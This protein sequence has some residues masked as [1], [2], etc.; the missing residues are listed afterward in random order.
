MERYKNFTAAIYCPVG[1][2]V[3]INDLDEFA[4]RFSWIEEHVRVGKVYLE[5]YRHGLMIDRQQM[6]RIRNFFNNKGIETA[7]GIT[8]D[9]IS[10]GEGG[11]DPLCYTNSD[12]IKLLTE[13]S[14]FTASLFDEIILDDF[15]FTNCRCPSCIRAKGDKTWARFRLDLMRDI[16]QNVIVK[17]AKRVNSKVKMVI[18]YPNWY[19]HYQDSGYDLE[20]EPQI[21]D[22]IY[23]GT[24]TRNPTYTQQHLPKYLSYFNVRYL[25]NVAPERNG[26]GWYDPYE[27][28]YNLT[29]YAQQAYLTLFAKAKEVMMFSLG[30]LLN[31]EYSLCIPINGQLFK[32]VDK[33]LGE[34]G[35]PIGVACYLPFHSHGEDY[36]HN[37]IGMLGIPLEPQPTYPEDAVTVFLT[38]SA[39]MDENIIFKVQKSLM[40]GADVIVTSGFLKASAPLGFQNMLANVRMT[41]RK[42][43]VNRYAY[44]NDGGICFEGCEESTKAILLPQL[45][46]QTNDTWELIAGLGEDNN[47]PILIKILYGKGCLYILTIPEDYGDI[48]NYPRKILFPI[49]QV[50]SRNI[51]VLLDA[52]SKIGFFIYDNHSF[53]LHLFQPWYDEVRLELKDGYTAIEDLVNQHIIQAQSEGEKMVVKLHLSPGINRVFKMIKG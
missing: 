49:R 30:S 50:F 26:G 32:D 29:S 10:N 39:A 53:I 14:E 46:F 47:F 11:F 42:A 28:S 43:F 44:S 20:N 12:T 24:E 25:E 5:T 19:E 21:F 23:T 8:T 16:A 18:K 35:K 51:P 1:D 34:L 3:C 15:F 45:E 40:D 48:Y 17:P 13:V 31:P 2:L 7:G 37:Y 36:L 41:D 9:G 33:Y 22:G 52:S 4:Q 27:C 6:E 38:E